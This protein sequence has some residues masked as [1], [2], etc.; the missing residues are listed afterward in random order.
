MKVLVLGSEG[1]LGQSLCKVFGSADL[2]WQAS[3]SINHKLKDV[4]SLSGCLEPHQKIGL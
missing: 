2:T 1:M 3:V 4:I